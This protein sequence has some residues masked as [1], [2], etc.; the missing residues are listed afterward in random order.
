L[1]GE[2]EQSRNGHTLHAAED[3]ELSGGVEEIVSESKPERESEKVKLN[4]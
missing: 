2:G 4:D 1:D 3:G